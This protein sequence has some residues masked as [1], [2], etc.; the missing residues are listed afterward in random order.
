M[1]ISL[2][3]YDSKKIKPKE[4][5]E[6]K[7]PDAPLKEYEWI[8]TG[9]HY[10]K[11]KRRLKESYSRHGLTWAGNFF[12]ET[13]IWRN[14]K[15]EEQVTNEYDRDY[16]KEKTKRV[17][18][19]AKVKNAKLLAEMSR[20]IIPGI[21]KPDTDEQLE[22]LDSKFKGI[23]A[24]IKNDVDRGKEGAAIW[25]KMVEKDYQEQRKK[26]LEGAD[27]RGEN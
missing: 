20:L 1:P 4:D 12:T 22:K 26:L 24:R 11:V 25:Y 10:H 9:E 8:I 5:F 6:L 23:L 17:T 7:S 13:F 3:E 16:T 27:G 15:T 18:I 14:P 2:E 19:K 21:T